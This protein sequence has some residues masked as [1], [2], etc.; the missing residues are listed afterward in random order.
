MQAQVHGQVFDQDQPRL[1][2][3]QIE[4]SEDVDFKT[5]G[6]VVGTED[7]THDRIVVLAAFDGVRDR[8]T[9]RVVL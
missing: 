9:R 6:F 3:L 4:P 5:F 2:A 8:S 1:P 7:G